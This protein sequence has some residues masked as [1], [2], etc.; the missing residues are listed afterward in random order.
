MARRDRWVNTAA[1]QVVW[2]ARQDFRMMLSRTSVCWPKYHVLLMLS[3]RIPDDETWVNSAWLCVRACSVRART[4]CAR[5][6]YVR[7][8][9][10][11]REIGT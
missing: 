6:A 3:E 8:K 1:L 10:R 2:T 4:R 5:F 7:F 9:I 11:L